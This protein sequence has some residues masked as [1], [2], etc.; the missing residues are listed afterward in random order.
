MVP[1]NL[2]WEETI[3]DKLREITRKR[4]ELRYH[5]REDQ[6]IRQLRLFKKDMSYQFHLKNEHIREQNNLGPL[7]ST[8]EI[9]MNEYEIEKLDEEV[10]QLS[11]R[12]QIMAENESNICDTLF[13]LKEDLKKFVEE[14]IQNINTRPAED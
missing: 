8:P 10:N 3:D 2:T 11:E 14:H 4:L 1:R 9:M 7:E 13:Y 6:R 12:L 5:L